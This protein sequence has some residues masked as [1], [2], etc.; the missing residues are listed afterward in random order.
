MLSRKEFLGEFGFIAIPPILLLILAGI[1]LLLL[2]PP[3]VLYIFPQAKLLFQV[4]MIFSVYMLV[5]GYLGSG[6]LTIIIT[7]VL[8]WF[9]VF[10]YPEVTAS[11]YVFWMLVM[12]GGVSVLIWGIGTVFR[13]H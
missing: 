2:L 5:R 3:A 12:F 8:I 13:P 10:K 4:I 9:L 6:M 11:L 7:A 1:V